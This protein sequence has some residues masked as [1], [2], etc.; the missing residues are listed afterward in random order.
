MMGERDRTQRENDA[1]RKKGI[2]GA[3]AAAF[4]PDRAADEELERMI[5]RLRAVPGT[6]GGKPA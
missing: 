3:L 5:G 4:L 1:A 2:G 6:S